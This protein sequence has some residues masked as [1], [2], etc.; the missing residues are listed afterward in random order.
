VK[1]K[2]DMFAGAKLFTVEKVSGAAVNLS[3]LQCL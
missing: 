3:E 2:L 1:Q